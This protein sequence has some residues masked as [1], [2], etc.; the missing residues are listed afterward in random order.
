MFN[1]AVFA[2]A[3]AGGGA[4]IIGNYH[5]RRMPSIIAQ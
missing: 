1:D 2:T 3:A 5:P 4:Y